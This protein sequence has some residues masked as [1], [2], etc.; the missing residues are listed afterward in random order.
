MEKIEYITNQF[1]KTFGKKYE[2]YC[3]TRIYNLLNRTD[4]KFVTQ[5][6]LKR[7]GEK[8]A[9][10]DLYLP[11]I[12]MWIEIDEGYHENQ[13]QSDLI[14]TNE[15]L[16]NYKLSEEIMKKYEALHEVIYINLEKPYRIVVYNKSLDEINQ[17]IDEVVLEIKKRIELKG[18]NFVPW[19]NTYSRPEDYIKI[20][21]LKVSDNSKFRTIKDIGKLF[22]I[23]KVPFNQLIHGYVHI[24]NNIYYWCPTL[25]IIGNECDKNAWENEMS[26]DGNIIYE[27]QK[28]KGTKYLSS[29]KEENPIRYVFTKYKDETETLA[30]K[31][32]GV[33]ILDLDKTIKFNQRTWIK[34]SDEI[35]L[36]KFFK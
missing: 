19:L 7:K 30:Y 22:N 32:K 3:I 25:K 18:T 11:Q 35:E 14:R 34:V 36:Y 12:N 20:R 24:L 27:N 6:L 33:F 17:Q 15:I 13:K 29:V 4:V 23:S 28:E 5:Q 10:A 16:E 1:K 21:K 9:L 26:E 2:N 8:I 31:F